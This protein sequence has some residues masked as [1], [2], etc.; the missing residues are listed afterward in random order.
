MTEAAKRPAFQFYPDKWQSDKDLRRC[1]IAARGLWIEM[2]CVM[3]TC[4]P[5]GHLT[6]NDGSPMPDKDVAQLCAVDLRTYR[7][8]LDE[9]QRKG[10]PS[11]TA[12]GVL[13]SRRMVRDEKVRIA[14]AEGGKDGAEFGMLGKEHG[15]KG[16]RPRKAEGGG[17]TGDQKPPFKPAPVVAFASPSSKP[18]EGATPPLS[19]L[20]PDIEPEHDDRQAGRPKATRSLAKAAREI[21]EF[22]NRRAG[23][24]FPDTDSNVGI[25]VARFKEGFTPEQVQRVV[26]MKIAQWNGNEDMREYLRPET[27]FGRKKFSQ[28]VGELVDPPAGTEEAA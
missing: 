25:I 20:P 3:H 14:R 1:S 24:R 12:T 18:E 6:D 5:Y 28:Y 4:A 26:A 7:A 22:L 27:L 10:V 16:G 15:K 2:C 11:R 21:L 9:L 13:F 17:V 8:L 23:K 19:G